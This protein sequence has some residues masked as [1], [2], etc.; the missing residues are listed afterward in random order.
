MD[1]ISHGPE[2]PDPAQ[3]DLFN[4]AK[5]E[6]ERLPSSWYERVQAVVHRETQIRSPTP[7]TLQFEESQKNGASVLYQKSRAL[8][9]KFFERK[10]EQ[11]DF[12]INEQSGSDVNP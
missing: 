11:H 9:I 3:L 1:I 2:T 5:N 8:A 6:P 7:E 12:F 4:Q 10:N